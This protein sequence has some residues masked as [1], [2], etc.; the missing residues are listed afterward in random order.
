[1][2][3][4]LLDFGGVVIKTPFELLHRV[5][6]PD[7]F[8]PFDPGADPLWSALQRGQI[9]ERDHWHQRA[10][11]VFPDSPDPVSDLMNA[12]FAPPSIEVLRPEVTDLLAEVD[13]PAV[14]TNDLAR[15]HG[16]AWLAEIGLNGSFE[17]L[18]DLSF[19]GTLKPH[20]DAYSH[21]LVELGEPPEN[22]VFVD[23]QP[24]NVAGAKESGMAAVWFDVTRPGASVELVRQ[25]LVGG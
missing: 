10:G 11:E 16:P 19:V 21:A 1:M 23:D 3:R 15:F 7:W 17:P 25:T 4:L 5:G 8:G 6:S 2:R 14:L 22:V 13:R 20:P 9:T 18:I 12:V 24:A